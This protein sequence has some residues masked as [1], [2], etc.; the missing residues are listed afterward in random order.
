MSPTLVLWLWFVLVVGLFCLDPARESKNSAAL[1]VPVIWL[2]FLE[3]RTPSLW[4]GLSDASNAAQALEQGNPLDRTMFSV[5]ISLVIAILVSRSFHWGKFVTQNSALACFLAF[6]LLSVAWSDFPFVTFRKWFRDLGLYGVILVVLSDPRPLEAVRTVLRRGAYLSIPLS[7]VLIKYYPALGKTFSAWGG[8][9]YTGVSTSKNMLGLLCLASGI[10]FFWDTITRWHERRETRIRRIILVNVVFIGITLW[11][12]NVSAS[13]TSTV[14][15]AIG[16][17]VIAAAHSNFGRRHPS[18]VKA[19]APASFFL[20]LILA[21]GF[22]MAG[23]L[24][25]AVGKSSHMSDRTRIWQVLLSVPINPIRGTGYQSFWL[26]SR[27]QWIWA[28]L[29]GD[30]VLEAHN[31][32]LQTYLELGLIGLFL[33]C[34]FLIATYRKVCKRLNPVTPLGSLSLGLWTLLLFYNVTEAALG[35]GVLWIILLMGSLTVPQRPKHQAHARRSAA[36]G[37][38]QHASLSELAG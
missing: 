2:F 17:L 10:F 11:L 27:V 9:E 20:Y 31:G 8:Q 34:A 26:G 33:V 32:Y 12:L 5:L 18:W 1:W 6:A 15:L 23:Q 21:L 25:E 19:L 28:R 22:G 37:T 14:C 30:N 35:G 24:S 7:V 29:T 36:P 3:S 4:L 16:C 13:S 38:E